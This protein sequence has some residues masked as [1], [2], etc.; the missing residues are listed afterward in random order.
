MNKKLKIHAKR[1]FSALLSSLTEESK[2]VNLHEYNNK[3]ES[4]SPFTISSWDDINNTFL[5]LYE[6]G[7]HS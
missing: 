1:K 3:N 4:S 2:L 7:Y 5:F 6:E